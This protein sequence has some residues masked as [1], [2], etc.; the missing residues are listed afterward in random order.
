MLSLA[1]LTLAPVKHS[2]N[3]LQD[4]GLFLPHGELRSV[5]EKLCA[6]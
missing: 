4:S 1:V 2:N 5:K 3:T 6:I